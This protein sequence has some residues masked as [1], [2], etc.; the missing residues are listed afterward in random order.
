M[1]GDMHK[2]TRA[3]KYE[4]VDVSGIIVGG[5]YSSEIADIE[6]IVYLDERRDGDCRLDERRI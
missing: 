3:E 4:Q 2:L 5:Q 1:L 6:H